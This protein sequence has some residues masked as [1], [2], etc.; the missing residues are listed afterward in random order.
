M[1]KSTYKYID[2]YIYIRLVQDQ[3]LSGDQSN[4]TH[5]YTHDLALEGL[6]NKNTNNASFIFASLD[7]KTF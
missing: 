6:L 3:N 7:Y 2:G 5:S 1:F 4:V